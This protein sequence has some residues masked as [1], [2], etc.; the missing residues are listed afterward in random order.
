MFGSGLRR[1][2]EG[3]EGGE[4]RD[5]LVDYFSERGEG[6]ECPD[7]R[8]DDFDGRFYERGDE[9]SVRAMRKMD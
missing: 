8:E 5:E 2:S 4:A 3:I 6:E 7:E 1:R 9:G